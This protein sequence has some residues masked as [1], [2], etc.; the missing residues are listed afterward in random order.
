[1]QASS[2]ASAR[3]GWLAGEGAQQVVGGG[4]GPDFGHVGL[5]WQP[6]RAGAA[7][8]V[9]GDEHPLAAHYPAVF[10]GLENPP[11]ERAR[12]LASAHCRPV[13]PGMNRI[14]SAGTWPPSVCTALADRLFSLWPRW[15]WDVAPLHFASKPA[16]ALAQ[17]LPRLGGGLKRSARTTGA[18]LLA[19]P[20]IYPEQQFEHRPAAHRRGL[21]RVAA[22]AEG[23]P[24]ARHL[25]QAPADG[26]G[27]ADALAQGQRVFDAGQ[28]FDEAPP[29]A[30][31]SASL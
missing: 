12:P 14:R 3:C 30:M 31:I 19:Q 5:F 28:L 8:G 17:P 22:K 6:V 24:A 10:I 15:V 29:V 26:F 18:C 27:G 2:A 16:T 23:N 9:A 1:M 7:A 21:L 13:R 20:G 4:F 11:A 25:P